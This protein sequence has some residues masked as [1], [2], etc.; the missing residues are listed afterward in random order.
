MRSPPGTKFA[1][2]IK[3]SD[4]SLKTDIPV[5]SSRYISKNM[6]KNTKLI[7]EFCVVIHP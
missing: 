2:F 7:L 4:I 3:F 5:T 1:I 6:Q